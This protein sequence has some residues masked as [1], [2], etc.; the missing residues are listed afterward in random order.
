IIVISKRKFH[1]KNDLLPGNRWSDILLIIFALIS[2]STSGQAQQ[3]AQLGINGLTCSMCSYSVENSIKK[4]PFIRSIK[5]DLN[6]NIAI[7]EFYEGKPVNFEAIALKVIDA[8]FA[9]RFLK[10]KFS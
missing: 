1:K 9:V 2:F 4:L 6:S 8:G 3:S 7:L 10:A 5:M